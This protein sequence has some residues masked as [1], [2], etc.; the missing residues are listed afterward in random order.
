MQPQVTPEQLKTLKLF[1]LYCQSYGASTA[2]K[3]YFVEN[4]SVDW[5]EEGFTSSETN[6]TI[7][8]YERIDEV[9]N[10]LIEDNELIE[11]S[12][13][14]CDYRGQLTIEIDCE[15]RIL[16]AYAMEWQYS[17][18]DSSESK[19]LEEISEEYDED[20]YNEV[21]RLFEQ[22]G[23]N[24]EGEISFQGGGDDGSID[25]DIIING[26]SET[27][28]KL[29]QDMVYDWLTRT[30]IDWYNNEGGQGRFLFIPKDGEIILEIGQNIEEDVIVPMDFEIQF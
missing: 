1:A 18:D 30:G 23:E 10:E 20:T 28:P 3:E 16:S 25:E 22:I 8:T 5:E 17:T 24:G 29:I 13:S 21:L 19:T 14:D 4:C 2:R 9:L 6:L 26:S 7:E 12:T 15:N 11:N 27:A